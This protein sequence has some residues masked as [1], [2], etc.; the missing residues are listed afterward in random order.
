MNIKKTGFIIILI[1]AFLS[2]I[3]VMMLGPV[4]QNPEYHI[5]TDQRTFFGI[6]NAWNVLSNLPFII[7]GFFGL[8]S[9]LRSHKM[10]LINEKK[11]AYIMFFA[12]VSMIA[13]GSGYYHLSPGNDTL[14]WDRLPMTIAFMALLS[15]II[16]EFTNS[17][18]NK[19]T[20]WPFI[21]IGIFSVVYWHITE[22]QGEGDLRLYILVQFFPMLAIPVILLFF[23]SK[24]NNVSGYWLLFCSYIFAKIFEYFDEAIQDI[25]VLFS[26]HTLKHLTAALGIF[27]LLKSYNN[28]KYVT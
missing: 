12:G 6:P 28:R 16:S 19:Y 5:F 13:V 22:R 17:H 3:G 8:N 1:I 2:V 23:K 15:I 26:G 9:I 10:K 20:L 24:F 11:T 27:F 18:M 7:F 4:S 25:L 14:V 21:F